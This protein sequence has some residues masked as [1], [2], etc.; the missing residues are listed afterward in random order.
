[1]DFWDEWCSQVVCL[2]HL[3]IKDVLRCLGIFENDIYVLILYIFI[4][5]FAKQYT[6]TQSHKIG[7]I[8]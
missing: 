6:Q 4:F 3:L 5:F 1:M 8:Y 2:W 7:D